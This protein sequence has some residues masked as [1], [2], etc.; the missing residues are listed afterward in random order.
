MKLARQTKPLGRAEAVGRRRAQGGLQVHTHAFA[1]MASPCMVKVET[2]DT[3]LARHLSQ[4]AEAEVRRIEAKFTRYK[5]TGI[6]WRINRTA[7]TAI[8]LDPETAGLLEYAASCHRLSVGRFDITSGILRRV[9]RFDG[10]DR[11]PLSAAVEVLLPFIG[12]DK[13]EWTNPVLRLRRGMEIDLGGICKEYAVDRAAIAIQALSDVPA[14]VNLGGDLRV[15]APKAEGRWK[16][17]IEAVDP[18]RR[19]DGLLEIAQGALATS[20]DACRFLLKQGTRYSHILEPRS[21]WPIV[22][23]PRSVTVAAATCLHAGT[24]ST[25]AMPQGTGAENFLK[26]EGVQSWVSR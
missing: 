10:S 7:G 12:W 8:E 24:L 23:P 18:A 20:G 3:A 4:A 16:V 13:V 19:S 9:W 17:A 5:D 2:E 11:V 26:R 1:A 22:D 25:L 6:V 21:G 15:T 14:L